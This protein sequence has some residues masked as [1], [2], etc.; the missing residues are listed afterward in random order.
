MSKGIGGGDT[1]ILHEARKILDTLVA[2][3][4]VQPTSKQI[5]DA[6]NKMEALLDREDL[7]ESEIGQ[8]RGCLGTIDNLKLFIEASEGSGT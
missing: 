3:V 7:D 5:D 8:V 4:G 1:L 6:M 2:R